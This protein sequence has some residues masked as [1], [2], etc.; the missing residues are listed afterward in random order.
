MEEPGSTSTLGNNGEKLQ[1][2]PRGV[3]RGFS[4]KVMPLIAQLDCLCSNARSM[5]NNQKEQEVM[6]QLE[7]CHI[8]ATTEKKVG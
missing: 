6:E 1:T 2:C 8:L 4:K 5:E 3:C 7:N